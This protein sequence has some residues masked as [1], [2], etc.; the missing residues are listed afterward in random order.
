MT[1]EDVLQYLDRADPAEI[2]IICEKA[3]HIKEAN[4]PEWEILYIALERECPERCR[5]TVYSVIDYLSQEYLRR[6]GK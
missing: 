3:M 1:M 2:D 5:R 4:Y 6:R